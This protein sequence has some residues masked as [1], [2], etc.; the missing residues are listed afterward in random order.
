[1]QKLLCLSGCFVKI[2]IKNIHN[3]IKSEVRC[4]KDAVLFGRAVNKTIVLVFILFYL[5][6]KERKIV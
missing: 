1:M 6:K 5:K 3:F 4:I 2:F